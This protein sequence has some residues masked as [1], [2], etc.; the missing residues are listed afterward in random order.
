M[1]DSIQGIK[2]LQFLKFIIKNEKKITIMDIFMKI[3]H[4]LSYSYRSSPNVSP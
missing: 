4:I 3:K 1:C 2:K